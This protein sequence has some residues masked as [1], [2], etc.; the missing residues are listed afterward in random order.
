MYP[1][2]VGL[3]ML[4]VGIIGFPFLSRNVTGCHRGR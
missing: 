1:A 4:Q 3:V 2:G